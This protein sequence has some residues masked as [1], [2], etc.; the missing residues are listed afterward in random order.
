VS[1]TSASLGPL[2]SSHA[3][4]PSSAVRRERGAA[5]LAFHLLPTRLGAKMGVTR[6]S[7]SEMKCDGARPK[8]RRR[9]TKGHPK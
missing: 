1:L 6:L 2:G 5:P 3:E 4:R 8:D 9:I 7:Q